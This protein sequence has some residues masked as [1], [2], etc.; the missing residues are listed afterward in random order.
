MYAI[1]EDGGKQY[2]AEP[3]DRVLIEL[4]ERPENA[5]DITFD[6][7]LMVGEGAAARIGQ[8][9]V[10]GVTVT[11]KVLEEFKTAKV[12]GIKHRRRKGYVKHWGHRQKMLRVEIGTINA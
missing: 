1:F 9:Y 5:T 3:G 8:P 4:R 10:A 12:H 7:V 11:G 2:K 6:K